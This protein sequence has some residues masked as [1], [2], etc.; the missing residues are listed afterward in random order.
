[1]LT[2][3]AG[4]ITGTLGV[5]LGVVPSLVLVP[6]VI[7]LYCY[8]QSRCG[9]PVLRHH[10][11]SQRRSDVVVAAVGTDRRTRQNLGRDLRR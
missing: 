10:R 11:R 9:D 5:L 3:A 8:P 1:M 2:M 4:S 6:M 7:A